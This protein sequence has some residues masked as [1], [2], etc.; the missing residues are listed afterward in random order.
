MPITCA[1]EQALLIDNKQTNLD[2]WAE[3]GGIGYL[4]RTDSAF[5]QDVAGGIENL[6]HR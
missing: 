5:E 1:N 3:R 2:A 4:Y 6:A